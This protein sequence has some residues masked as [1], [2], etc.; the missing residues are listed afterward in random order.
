MID[1]AEFGYSIVEC[2][3]QESIEKFYIFIMEKN[4][5]EQSFVEGLKYLKEQERVAMASLISLEVFVSMSEKKECEDIFKNVII[6]S[7]LKIQDYAELLDIQERNE[8]LQYLEGLRNEYPNTF[9]CLPQ[10]S[11]IMWS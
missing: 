6:E 4:L 5:T 7:F 1:W 3:L 10:K 8:V 11:H 2:N 9:I